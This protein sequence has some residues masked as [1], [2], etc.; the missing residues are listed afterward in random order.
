MLKE[1]G[2]SNESTVCEKLS[3]AVSVIAQP[4]LSKVLETLKMFRTERSTTI[5]EERGGAGFYELNL[6]VKETEGSL[7]LD[8]IEKFIELWMKD[9]LFQHLPKEFKVSFARAIQ[10]EYALQSDLDPRFSDK[11]WQFRYSYGNGRLCGLWLKLEQHPS[12]TPGHVTYKKQIFVGDFLPAPKY[13]II[14]KV[15]SGFFYSTKIDEVRFLPVAVTTEHLNTIGNH[16]LALMGAF[17][18]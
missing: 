11:A 16:S 18:S 13:V 8:R 15:D 10:E 14:T 17:Q 2:E 12:G 5:G 7:M 4:T 1:N 9:P 6:E 3:K